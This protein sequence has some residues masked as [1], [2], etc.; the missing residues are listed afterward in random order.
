MA[1]DCV[2]PYVLPISFSTGFFG[3]KSLFLVIYMF[4]QSHYIGLMGC[5]LHGLT[6]SPTPTLKSSA[7]VR[8]ALSKPQK[9]SN[10]VLY[11]SVVWVK[12][13]TSRKA[14]TNIRDLQES[15]LILRPLLTI[16]THKKPSSLPS[17][18][19]LLMYASLTAPH[20]YRSRAHEARH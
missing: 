16:L 19:F 11:Q 1:N 7:T 3:A 4:F 17:R 18:T 15:G 12:R 2:A 5:F 20:S 9:S 10:A 8:T 13:V 6:A 14:E